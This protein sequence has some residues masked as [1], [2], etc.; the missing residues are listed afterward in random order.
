MGMTDNTYH[1]PDYDGPP[2]KRRSVV[3][4]AYRGC[5][6]TRKWAGHSQPDTW[7]WDHPD[8]DG[9]PSKLCGYGKTIQACHDEIDGVMEDETIRVMTVLAISDECFAEYLNELLD[10]ALGRDGY[11]MQVVD[12]PMAEGRIEDIEKKWQLFFHLRPMV[13][14]AWTQFSAIKIG[15]PLARAIERELCRLGKK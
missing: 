14:A 13:E 8:Y 9:P 2:S 11:E 1:G 5:T 10:I 3:H 12:G 4:N 6:I 7:C 15:A